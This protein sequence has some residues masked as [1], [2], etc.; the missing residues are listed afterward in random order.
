MR[1][2]KKQEVV[3][4]FQQRFA[5]TKVLI[6]TDYKGLDVQAL[7]ELRGK[8]RQAGSEFH[9]VK[10]SLLVRA[11]ADND[12][13]VIR[14]H[15]K[16]PSGVALSTQ[17]PVAP[18]KVLMDFAKTND[19]LEIKVGVLNGR[20]LTTEDIKALAEL[21]SREA[22]LASLLGLLQ[23]VPASFVRTLNAIPQ[24]M[25]NLLQALKDQR[26]SQTP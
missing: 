21:P 4:D 10:N 19:K 17:D 22:L 5:K 7:N 16:G 6:L 1:L 12:I 20:A 26:A 9:V 2:E 25:L 13:G 18:A 24:K 8:L 3:S 11:S 23:G 14:D 15:F